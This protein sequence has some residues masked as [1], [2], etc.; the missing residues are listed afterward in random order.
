M[1]ANQEADTVAQIKFIDWVPM[2]L[3]HKPP[4]ALCE[5]KAIG[6]VIPNIEK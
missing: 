6:P 4:S 2:N 3:C 1:V 5:G